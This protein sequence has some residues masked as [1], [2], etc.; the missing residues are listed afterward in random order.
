MFLKDSFQHNAHF[1]FQKLWKTHDILALNANIVSEALQITDSCSHCPASKWK[2]IHIYQ[3][4][5]YCQEGCGVGVACLSNAYAYACAYP[6]PMPGAWGEQAAW[7]PI[8]SLRHATRKTLARSK[9]PKPSGSGILPSLYSL[10]MPIKL[11]MMVVTIMT[12]IDD[13]W[14]FDEDDWNIMEALHYHFCTEIHNF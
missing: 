11:M 7:C 10:N 1:K 6:M 4:Y 9:W 8:P 3:P 2:V 14:N 12:R 13:G 5:L